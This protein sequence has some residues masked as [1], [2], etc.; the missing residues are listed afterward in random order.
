MGCKDGFTCPS[1]G[2]SIATNQSPPS[3]NDSNALETGSMKSTEDLIAAEM[4]KLSIHEISEALDDV[5]C[6]GG[7]LEETPEMIQE[8][9]L[10]FDEE[11]KVQKNS[12]Y[13]VAARQDQDYVENEAFRLKFLRA[14][15][16]DVKR[17]V[18]QMM[19]FLRYKATYFGASKVARDI[20]LSDL[21][22]EDLGLL[23]SGLLH[24]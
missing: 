16:Y 3:Q 6:V 14:N 4:N 13:D 22:K 17:S 7:G 18:R 15:L 24:I 2:Y 20:V 5:H 9:L 10:A 23:H 19:N 12:I 11:V 21:N 8:S 1:T